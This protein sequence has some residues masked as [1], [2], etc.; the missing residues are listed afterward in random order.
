[1]KIDFIEKEKFHTTWFS[2]FFNPYFFVRRGLYIKVKSYAHNLNGVF[3]DF[4]CG[5]KPYRNLFECENYI[6]LDIFSSGHSHKKSKVDMFYDGKEIPFD[7]EYFDSIFSSEVLTHT[8]N[9][10]DIIQEINRVL[11]VG[12]YLL[13]TVPFVWFENEIPY[14]NNRYTS[15]GIKYL[16]EEAGFTIVKQDKTTNFIQTLFQLFNAYLFH[17]LGSNLVLRILIVFL[18]IVPLNLLGVLLSF[19]MP[20]D[21]SLFHNNV[22]LAVKTQ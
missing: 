4:G 1:M 19:V 22:I 17:N 5:Q 12:G 18:I 14:D 20:K 15:F 7:N 21:N 11:K 3:L 9:T 8:F 16:L 6:G 13:I 2:I 10:K